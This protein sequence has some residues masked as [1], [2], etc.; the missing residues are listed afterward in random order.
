MLMPAFINIVSKAPPSLA[1]Q[2]FRTVALWLIG[3]WF[4]FSGLKDKR[5]HWRG[6]GPMPTWLGRTVLIVFGLFFLGCT[7]FLWN[8]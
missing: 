2:I 7:F 1:L 6:G 3:A 4:V 8:K 5:F